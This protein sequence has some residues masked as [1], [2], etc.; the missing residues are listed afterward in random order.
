[1]YT[2]E[3]QYLKVKVCEKGA[4][5]QSIFDK[6][7]GKEIL[8]TADAKFWARRSPILF[9]NVG[10]HHENQYFYNGKVYEAIQHGFAKD[11]EFSC[12]EETENTL[13]FII[14][15]TEETKKYY[16]FSFALTITYKIQ[17]RKLDVIWKVEN[18]NTE[19]MYFTIGGHPGFNVPILEDTCQTDYKLLFKNKGEV[20]YCQ[21]Y[22]MTGTADEKKTY[23]LPLEPYG[24]YEGCNVTETMFEND[25]LIFDNSQLSCVGIGYPDGIPYIMMD[26]TGFT[27]FGIWSLP[28]APYICLE[29]WMGRC[30]NYGFKDDISKKPDIVAL[31]PEETF[32]HGYSVTIYN[33]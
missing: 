20:E 22:G 5:L 15:D 2:M 12:V 17:D 28:G 1:M 32:Q 4:E 26:C 30:D 3:N 6:E 18:K 14:Q 11:M 13:S 16:P 8:W 10:R 23:K 25:A 9:P 33:K 27:D 7:M 31:K 19:T 24:E 29:P 21:V